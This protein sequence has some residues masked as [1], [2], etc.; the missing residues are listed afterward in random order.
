MLRASGVVTK[1]NSARFDVL[2]AE[3]WDVTLRRL[4]DLYIPEDF[5]ELPPRSTVILDRLVVFLASQEI[6]PQ[7]M[8]TEGSL[9]SQQKP[10]TGPS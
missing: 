10:A 8:E 6:H 2:T 1:C 9:Q 7:F 4:V 5:N 3:F